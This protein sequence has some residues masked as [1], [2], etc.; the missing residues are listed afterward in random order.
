MTCRTIAAGAYASAAVLSLALPGVASAQSAPPP[1]EP[2]TA[3]EEEVVVLS[4]FEVTASESTGY[5]ATTTLAGSRINTQL[6]DVGSAVSVITSEFMRD[7]GATDN[8]TLLQYATA[9]EVGSIGGN[10][11]RASSSNQQEETT[12]TTPN[13]N[14]RVR[15]LSA[16]DNTRNFFMSEIP[17]DAYNVD[18]VDMQRGPNSILFGMGSPAGIINSTTKTAQFRNMGEAEVR[19]GSNGTNRASLDLNQQLIANELAVRV[20]LLRNDERYKQKPAYSLD[21]RL[22][23]TARWEPKFIGNESNKTTIK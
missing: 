12:F 13:T 8:K 5:V 18:R 19:L 6:K 22:F 1:S 15:G 11:I 16:A 17:W 3:S 14:T 10:F 4:P 20:A 23:A 21:K 7:T 9:T 2:P